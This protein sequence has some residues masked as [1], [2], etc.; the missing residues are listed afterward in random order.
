MGV[1]G[2]V[3]G[4]FGVFFG[5][6]FGEVSGRVLFPPLVAWT[7]AGE[8]LTDALKIKIKINQTKRES[9]EKD[10]SRLHQQEQL[11]LA[12]MISFMNTDTHS[13]GF[14]ASVAGRA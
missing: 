1:T 5:V 7:S 8:A 10:A 6:D 4:C 13:L 3:S 9:S 12:S 2:D 14:D 11:G